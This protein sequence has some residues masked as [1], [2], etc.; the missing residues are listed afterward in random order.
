MKLRSLTKLLKSS[1]KRQSEEL[2][3]SPITQDQ[4]SGEDWGA[5]E[6]ERI[7]NDSE[8][9]DAWNGLRI[10]IA[11]VIAFLSIPFAMGEG[12]VGN[13]MNSNLLLLF[14]AFAVIYLIYSFFKN[15]LN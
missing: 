12:Y 10:I 15:I 5:W 13:H 4:D 9:E 2:N 7:D 14:G 11:F 8:L 6:H 1:K 3:K